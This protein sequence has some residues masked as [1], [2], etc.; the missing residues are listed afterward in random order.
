MVSSIQGTKSIE[1]GTLSVEETEQSLDLTS[2][3][4]EDIE[5]RRAIIPLM[6]ILLI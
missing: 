3:Q 5:R 4:V 1:D 6:P 2:D